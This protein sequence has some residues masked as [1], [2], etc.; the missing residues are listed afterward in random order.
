MCRPTHGLWD[1]KWGG[2]LKPA[3]R[4]GLDNEQQGAGNSGS[5]KGWA[6]GG[7]LGP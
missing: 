4:T 7:V 3:P 1:V 5:T 2:D 6:G